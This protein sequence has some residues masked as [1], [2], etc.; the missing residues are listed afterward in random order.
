MMSP[1]GEMRIRL[2]LVPLILLELSTKRV[3]FEVWHSVMPS[4]SFL[5]YARVLGM[6][7][8]MKFARA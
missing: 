3:H 2:M 4:I 8:D 7:S 1:S 6:K 5:A